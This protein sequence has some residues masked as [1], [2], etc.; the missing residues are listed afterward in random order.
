MYQATTQSVLETHKRRE[1]ERK[2]WDTIWDEIAYFVIPSRTGFITDFVPGERRR[3]SQRYD[4]TAVQANKTLANHIH[5]SLVNPSMQWGTTQFKD[6]DIQKLDIAKEWIEDCTKRMHRAYKDSNFRSQINALFQVLPAMGTACIEVN[7]ESTPK[8]PFRLLFQGVKL[9]NCTFDVDAQGRVDTKVQCY[10]YTPKQ[11][12]ELWPENGPE[13]SGK[14]KLE[15]LKITRPNPDYVPDSINPK[16]REYL[17]EYCHRENV[18]KTETAYE[19]PFMCVRYDEIDDDDIYGEG[20]ALVC[21]SDIRS[22]NVA[23]ELELRG[24][25][26]AIDPPLMGAAGAVLSDL[27]QEAGG[28]T[29]VRDPRMIGELPGRMDINS[30]MIKGEELRDAI[31]RAYKINEILVPERKGQNPATATEVQVRYE[32]AQKMLGSTAGRIIDELLVPLHDR[33]FGL[34]HRN[35][36]FKPMP[37]ELQGKELE[38][39]FTGPLVKS[40]TSHEAVA[41]ERAIQ[42]IMGVGQ[43]DADAILTLDFEKMVRGIVNQYGVPADWVRSE[44]E[45]QSLI[46]KKRAAEA[47][48]ANQ[49]HRMAEAQ[50]EEQQAVANNANV[51]SMQNV[52]GI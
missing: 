39:V 12:A 24:Y 49:E 46:K 10:K 14:D 35:G 40:Q 5:M 27:H 41:A 28:F 33:V 13:E 1:S 20:P 2:N 34:M 38:V 16:E 25:E 30:V 26:K 15:I 37:K 42:L 17:I 18:F 11:I 21:L 31:N 32:Q 19:Q 36:Q 51:E 9:S 44:T 4:S 48:A 23:K 22:I 3:W 47:E 52:R 6:P 50:I 45:V 43:I 8:H 29:S 7:M